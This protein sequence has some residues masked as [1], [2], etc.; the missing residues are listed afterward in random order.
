ML[1]DVLTILDVEKYLT[2]NEMQIGGF[3]LLYRDGCRYAPS[4]DSTF[5]SFIGCANNRLTQLERLAKARAYEFSR[6]KAEEPTRRSS[7]A[8]EEVASLRPTAA[9]TAA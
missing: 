1:D 6:Q 5:T 3:D 2:G 4:E 8:S 9:N 7:T